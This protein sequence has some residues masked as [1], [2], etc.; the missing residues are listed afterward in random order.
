MSIH[1]DEVSRITREIEENKRER[2]FQA[3]LNNLKSHLNDKLRDNFPDGTVITWL[4]NGRYRYAAIRSGGKWYKTGQ[5]GYPYGF[6]GGVTL[7]VLT[8]EVFSR[9]DVTEIRVAKTFVAL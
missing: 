4:G 3:S 8:K 5:S 2:D 9:A 1:P 7:N 6:T